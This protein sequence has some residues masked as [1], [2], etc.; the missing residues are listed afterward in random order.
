[1]ASCCTEL[2]YDTKHKFQLQLQASSSSTLNSSTNSTSFSDLEQTLL[3]LGGHG[4][5]EF[6]PL[7]Y[8]FYY[9][10]I[11]QFEQYNST[12]IVGSS[13]VDNQTFSGINSLFSMPPTDLVIKFYSSSYSFIYLITQ[14]TILF[15]SLIFI[16]K[17]ANLKSIIVETEDGGHRYSDCVFTGWE[18]FTKDNESAK[19]KR[20]AIRHQM[21]LLLKDEKYKVELSI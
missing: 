11:Q 16:I 12:T 15:I 1:M 13:P 18:Y 19:F 10:Q 20:K 6:S 2:Y 9:Y 7:Y 3:L 14:L 8:G 4:K 5:N 17:Q 21:K